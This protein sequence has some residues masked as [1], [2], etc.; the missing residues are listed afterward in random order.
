MFMRLG[1][2]EI[3][4]NAVAHVFGNETTIAL[5]YVRGASLA[6]SA[7]EPTTSQNMTESWRRPAL[8]CAA[9]L[10]AVA[11]GGAGGD[12]SASSRMARSSFLRCPSGMPIFSKLS[13]SSLSHHISICPY[14]PRLLDN[15][16]HAC[17]WFPRLLGLFFESAQPGYTS[18]S[19]RLRN[20]PGR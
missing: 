12:A 19:R 6:D 14:T 13:A 8:S 3:R 18:D 9:G 17:S 1:I 2:A 16:W 15:P 4:E 7:V 11:G 5:D 10:E 20:G